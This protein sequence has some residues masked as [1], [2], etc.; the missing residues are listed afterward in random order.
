MLEGRYS[1]ISRTTWTVYSPFVAPGGVIRRLLRYGYVGDGGAYPEYRFP[2]N[3]DVPESEYGKFLMA[4]YEV[5]HNFVRDA[6]APLIEKRDM[7]GNKDWN[8]VVNWADHCAQWV[9]GFPDGEAMNDANVL[10]LAASAIIWGQSV[11]HATDHDSIHQMRPARL[12]FRLRVPPPR[13]GSDRPFRR[14]AL[15]HWFDLFKTYLTDAL[16]YD[17]HNVTLLKD[18][19]YQF[20]DPTLV[21]RNREFRDELRQVEVELRKAGITVFSPLAHLPN[22]IQY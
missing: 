14:D 12:P 11:S 7:P 13:D 1:L 4:Y 20:A 3:P 17:P 5:I 8:W 19:D 9:P 10:V 16:F 15:N 18:V 22:S 6:L 21:Q 2:L